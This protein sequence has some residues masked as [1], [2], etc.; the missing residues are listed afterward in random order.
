M[1]LKI[2]L[3]WPWKVINNGINWQTQTFTQLFAITVP[4]SCANISVTATRDTLKM[5]VWSLWELS[6]M[7]LVWNVKLLKVNV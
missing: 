4:H 2:I 7:H 6:S 3:Q 5:D 1:T